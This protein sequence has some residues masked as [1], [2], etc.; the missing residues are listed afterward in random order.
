MEQGV[1]HEAEAAFPFAALLGDYGECILMQAFVEASSIPVSNRLC[2]GSASILNGDYARFRR[3]EGGD[4]CDDGVD[5]E[6]QGRGLVSL[7]F[8]T[9][10]YLRY[11]QFQRS[12]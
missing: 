8:R 2:S 7:V 12:S 3:G 5:R 6:G 9:V 11:P 4:G 10:R 1:G